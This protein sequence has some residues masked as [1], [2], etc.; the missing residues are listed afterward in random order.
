MDRMGDYV[1]KQMTV[2]SGIVEL[3]R[4]LPVSAG[5]AIWRDVRG[6][7]EFYSLITGMEVKLERGFLDLTSLAILAGYKF[8]SK[9]MTAMGVQVHGTLLNKTVS[10]GDNMWSIR[11]SEIPKALQCYALGDIRFGF[12]T[13]NVLAG[14]LL[15]DV[16]PDPDMLCRYLKYDQG[17]AV[18]WFLDFVMVSLEGVEYHQVA[19]EQAQTRD[20]MVRSLR[21]RD[22]RERLCEFSPAY[23]KVWAE[24]LGAWPSPTFGGCRFMLQCREWFVTQMRIIAGARIQWT[25]DR[26]I[27]QPRDADLEYARFGMTL[28]EIGEQT[29]MDPVPGI[30]GRKKPDG[31]R[32]PVLDF[33]V[34]TAKS[35]DI[36]S[37]CTEIGRSQH[38]ACWNGPD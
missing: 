16:F 9:N 30:R 29:W 1:L 15:R 27:R 32:I 8:H 18:S 21:L 37:K 36:G 24:I 33:D 14:L 23:V 19:D 35:S 28:E 17:S 22:S 2:Q 38:G 20:E 26:V 4:D 31:V 34:S 7:E 3:L 6:V 12:V 5:L 13:Y 11:W 10:T 25:D